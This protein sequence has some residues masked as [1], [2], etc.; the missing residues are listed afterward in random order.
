MVCRRLGFWFNKCTQ[1]K[2]VFMGYCPV[3]YVPGEDW[4]TIRACCALVQPGRAIV[5]AIV[6]GGGGLRG[7]DHP[8]P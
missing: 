2:T 6:I 4:V 8:I 7:G 1:L 5:I 3:S